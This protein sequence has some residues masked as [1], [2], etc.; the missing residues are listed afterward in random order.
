MNQNNGNHS[1][2]AVADLIDHESPASDS[3]TYYDPDEPVLKPA[4]PVVAGRGK[5]WK[6]SLI[7]W[8]CILLLI[9]GGAIALYLLVKVNRVPVRVQADSG[10]GEA[11][12]NKTRSEGNNSENNLTAEAITIAR[13]ASGNDVSAANNAQPNA[14]P[15]PSPVPSPAQRFTAERSLAFTGNMSPVNES[16]ANTGG[17]GDAKEGGNLN[18]AQ[19]KA[20]DQIAATVNQSHANVT[21]SI[22]IEDV[23]PRLLSTQTISSSRTKASDKSPSD[24]AKTAPAVL[25]PFGTMLP[26]RTQGVIFTVR[27]NSFARMELTRDCAGPG[28]SLAKG[29]ILVGRTSGGE[30]D[31]AFVNIVGYIDPR[32]NKLVKLSGD[33]L[34]ADGASGL[35]GKRIG[36]DRNRL[37]QTLSKV[38]SS[39][40]QVAGMMAGALTGRGAVVIDGAGY[41][42]TSP[43][44]DEARGML[45]NGSDR[46][47]FV[48]VQ[49]GQ[50]AYVMVA[51]LPRSEM[52]VDA[53]G[54]NEITN[55]AHALTDREVMELILFG[56]PEDIRAATPL[57]S[58]EQKQ[59]VLKSL[60]PEVEKR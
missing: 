14:S 45:G 36:V 12:R 6:R 51:D 55:A 50:A 10:S 34:G 19:L 33:V 58:D 47:S 41:R 40:V 21:Q 54:A 27:N 48:K 28:W 29:T 46:N 22:F 39:G 43:I 4:K 44:T 49:A 35:P 31:R 1:R 3:T 18:P 5:S 52:G 56:T 59:L 13:Q 2:V 20:A 38:A 17:N 11:Q 25:P 7:K 8:C 23:Q 15:N 9:G 24:K 57:M 53:P 37:K 60:T 30:Y 42:L 26:V 16:F 32:D